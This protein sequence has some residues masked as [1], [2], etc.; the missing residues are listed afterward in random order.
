M[1][2][3]PPPDGTVGI[4]ADVVQVLLI[5]GLMKRFTI[6]FAQ[7]GSDISLNLVIFF[8]DEQDQTPIITP[9]GFQFLLMDAASQIW[10]F[11]LKYL[12]TVEVQ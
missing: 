6:Y 7:L 1:T 12:D 9:S 5:S 8:S 4:S 2:G 3:S 11:M 10:Y